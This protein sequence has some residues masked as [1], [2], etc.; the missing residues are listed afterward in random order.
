MNRYAVRFYESLNRLRVE[1][2][3]ITLSR[4]GKEMGVSRQRAQAIA[5][6]SGLNYK[7]I[8]YEANKD[9]KERKF[10]SLPIDL[11]VSIL[12]NEERKKEKQLAFYRLKKT[13]EKRLTTIP[14][15]ELRNLTHR[16]ILEK[17][18]LPYTKKGVYML[19]S[20]NVPYLRNVRKRL[21]RTINTLKMLKGINTSEYTVKELA[22]YVGIESKYMSQILTNYELPYKR[23]YI[24]EK[25]WK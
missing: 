17:I 12:A 4:M 7:K 5:Q 1:N 23:V 2:T 21:P 3:P 15:D 20:L 18:K 8:I 6:L 24:R 25:K 22:L 14:E 16:Q 19:M 11:Q 9:I 10:K 13:I